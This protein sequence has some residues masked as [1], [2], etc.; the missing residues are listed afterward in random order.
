MELIAAIIGEWLNIYKPGCKNSAFTVAA[1]IFFFLSIGI[2]GLVW[3]STDGSSC[4][5][6]VF[7]AFAGIA[8]VALLRDVLRRRSSASGLDEAGSKEETRTE[9]DHP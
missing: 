3:G 9:S 6:A 7:L 4:V 1:A 8:M 5:G 2:G